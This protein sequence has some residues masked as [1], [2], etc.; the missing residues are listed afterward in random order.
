M[1][2]QCGLVRVEVRPRK[3]GRP[4]KKRWIEVRLPNGAV[5]RVHRGADPQIARDLVAAVAA[6][7]AAHGG[8]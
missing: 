6:L 8:P 5:V 2:Q 1:D 3:R 7:P 4:A